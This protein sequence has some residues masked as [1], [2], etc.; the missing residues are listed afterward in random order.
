MSLNYIYYDY[1]KVATQFRTGLKH[2]MHILYEKTPS[3]IR[4]IKP[5]DSKKSSNYI[6]D[7]K[8]FLN[9]R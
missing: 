3:Y 1:I 5:N 8:V 7:K 4:C 2:L 9:N 6:N